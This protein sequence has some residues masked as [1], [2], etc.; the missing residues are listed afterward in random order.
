MSSTMSATS[1]KR[2]GVLLVVAGA[3]FRLGSGS[4]LDWYADYVTDRSD[5][6]F[7]VASNLFDVIDAVLIPLG[8]AL[9]A[10]GL[11]VQAIRDAEPRQG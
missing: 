11:V 4:M 7:S 10:G 6:Q 1:M 2:W 5:L 3:A 9:L 8:V